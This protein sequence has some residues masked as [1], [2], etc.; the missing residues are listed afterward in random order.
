MAQNTHSLFRGIDT[1]GLRFLEG[2]LAIL[3]FRP[4][5]ELIHEGARNSDLFFID[6]GR[7]ALIKGEGSTAVTLGEQGPGA[8]LGE[9]SFLDDSPRSVTVRAINDVVV[10]ALPKQ[11]FDSNDPAAER[12]LHQIERN[13]AL[14]ST[15]RLRRTSEDFVQS[16]RREVELLREQVDFGTLFIIMV[17]LFGLNGFIL[18]IIQQHFA[19]YYYYSSPDF[20]FV[21]SALIDWIGFIV[22]ALP[23]IFLVKII[24]FPIREVMNLSTNL[25]QTLRESLLLSAIVIVAIVPATLGLIPIPYLPRVNDD[26]DLTWLLIA[27]SP[28]YLLHAYIQELVARG[29]MQNAIQKFLRDE[30]G[31]KT[32]IICSF[33]FAIMH[34]HLG[35]GFALMTGLASLAFGYIYL[36]HRNLLGVTLVH[37]VTGVVAMRYLGILNVLGAE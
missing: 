15:D 6:S 8:V 12:V 11:A 32:V 23:V 1:E 4:G 37:Y 7:V 17:I 5:D 28:D 25:R 21:Y 20:S 26:F 16:L 19:A 31:H 14:L 35:I 10:T 30:K 27:I 22:F 34:V 36:R 13:I 33:A 29:I 18:N 3:H 24:R 2:H 9:L